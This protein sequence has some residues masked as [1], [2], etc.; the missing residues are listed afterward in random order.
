MVLY[1]GSAYPQFETEGEAK[2]PETGE[3]VVVMGSVEK[4]AALR[5]WDAEVMKLA[6]KV[7]QYLHPDPNRWQ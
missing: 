1:D 5:E 3:L 7:P 2:I 6:M 4:A